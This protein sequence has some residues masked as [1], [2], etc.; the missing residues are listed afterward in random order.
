MFIVFSINQNHQ[1]S[2]SSVNGI[3]RAMRLALI[4]ITKSPYHYT[5]EKD[6]INSLAL[7]K[8]TKSPYLFVYHSLVS[9]RLALIKIT[10]SPYQRSANN[11]Y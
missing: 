11:A 4:K 2:V 8:I 3:R 9:R 7:I 6:I 5:I 1:E 10:K